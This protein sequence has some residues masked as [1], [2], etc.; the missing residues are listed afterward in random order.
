[1][2]SVLP[3]SITWGVMALPLLLLTGCGGGGGDP[4]DPPPTEAAR[5]AA[6]ADTAQSTSNACNPI[7]PFYW[8]VGNSAAA[9]VAGSVPGSAGSAT[10]TASTVMNVASASKWLYGA[11]VVQRRNGVLTAED[12]K[13]LHFRSGYTSF[14]I[15]LPGDTVNSCLL[16][17]SND[18]YTAANDGKFYYDGGHMQKH[19]DLMGLGAMGNAALADELR[20][21][22]G[23]DIAMA[24]SQ[25]QPAGGVTSTAADYA[26]FLRKLLAG[27]LRLGAILGTQAVCT[28]PA[29]CASAV[30]TPVPLNESWDYSLGHWVEVDPIKGDGAFSSAGAFGFYPWIDAGKTSYG[31]VARQAALGSGDDSM[32]CGRLIRKAWLTGVAQ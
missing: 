9:K 23:T 32:Y 19:A 28:N 11:Y 14:S 17:G 31:I 26:R 2:R 7:R 10:Y 21:Q 1:M 18:T 30:A 20:S 24:Y 27:N 13:F 22:L 8:E 4:G 29:I 6:A 25:P 15:C 5:I 16:R 12:I 3:R